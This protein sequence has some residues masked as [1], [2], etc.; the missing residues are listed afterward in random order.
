MEIIII[1]LTITKFGAIY[2][3]LLNSNLVKKIS[4]IHGQKHIFCLKL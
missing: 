1:M 3:Y 2:F 4:K